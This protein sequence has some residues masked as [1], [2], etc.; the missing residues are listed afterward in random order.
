MIFPCGWISPEGEYF[1]VDHGTH[2]KWLAKHIGKK[3][4]VSFSKASIELE[5]SLYKQGWIHVGSDKNG[6][7]CTHKDSLNIRSK[8]YHTLQELCKKSSWHKNLEICL[9]S[10]T[11][12]AHEY[13]SMSIGE[14][15][16]KR[17]R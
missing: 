15:L 12:A 10:E 16:K 17:F 4:L 8:S 5:M 7:I 9:T 13:F 3:S 2:I 14:F 6:T 1:E 11:G